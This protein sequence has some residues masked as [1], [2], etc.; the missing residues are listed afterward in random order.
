[1]NSMNRKKRCLTGNCEG[2]AA[3]VKYLT[4]SRSFGVLV[5]ACE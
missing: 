3:V 4:S 2:L 5:Y 1:M